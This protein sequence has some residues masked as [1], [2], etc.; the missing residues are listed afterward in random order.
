MRFLFCLNAPV[1]SVSDSPAEFFGDWGKRRGLP[2]PRLCGAPLYASLLLALPRLGTPVLPALPAAAGRVLSPPVG[3][4]V[5]AGAGAWRRGAGGPGSAVRGAAGALPHNIWPAGPGG[6][7]WD[8]GNGGV[9]IGSG[10]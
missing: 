1:P 4:E 7:I 8:G 10:S 5:A 3:A 9:G 6:H 2:L